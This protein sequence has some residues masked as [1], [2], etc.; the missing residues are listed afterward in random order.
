MA[1]RSG[2]STRVTC[3]SVRATTFSRRSKAAT[4]GERGQPCDRRR[5]VRH[6]GRLDLVYSDEQGTELGVTR[7]RWRT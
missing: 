5:T 1:W 4:Q 3:R 6:G 7:R 2:S